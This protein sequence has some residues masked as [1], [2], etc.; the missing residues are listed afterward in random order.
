VIEEALHNSGEIPSHA[1]L[2]KVK[3]RIE[4]I[5]DLADLKKL[6]ESLKKTFKK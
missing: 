1:Q 2:N 5:A 6:A 3:A 4:F